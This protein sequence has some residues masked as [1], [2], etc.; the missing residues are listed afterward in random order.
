MPRSTIKPKVAVK[1]KHIQIRV[2][3]E[4]YWKLF[5]KAADQDMTLRQWVKRKIEAEAGKEK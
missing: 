1:Y 3:E 5:R 4:I 2:T